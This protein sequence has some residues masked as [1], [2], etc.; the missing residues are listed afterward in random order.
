MSAPQ[1]FPNSTDPAVL[2]V[3]SYVLCVF[4]AEGQNPDMQGYAVRLSNF[5]VNVC[6][7]LLIR[8]SEESVSESVSALLLQVYTLMLCAFISLIRKQLSVADAHFA[9]T[10]TVSPLA[11]YLLYA[12]VR[13]VL[14]KRSYLFRRLGDHRTY[15]TL[16]L[17][18][19]P[20][21]TIMNLLIY[22]ANVFS[23]TCAPVTLASWLLFEIEAV[24]FSFIFASVF[25]GI[26]VLVWIF[27]SLRHFRDIRGEY[28]RHKMKAQ[29]WA[30]FSWIQW[31][32]LSFKSFVLAQW[33]VITKSHPWILTLSISTTY[34]IWGSSLILYVS[35]LGEFYH[36]IVAGIQADNG[37]PVTPYSPPDGYD[38]L[39]YGQLLAAGVAF[40]PLWQVLC[41]IWESR[42][43]MLAWIKR[44][45]SSLWNGIIFIFTG[46]R[47]PWEKVLAR[48]AEDGT[49][50]SI[51]DTLP[52]TGPNE[53]VK[54]I[55]RTSTFTSEV[56]DKFDNETLSNPAWRS[57]TS[58]DYSTAHPTSTTLY[59][60]YSP[61]KSY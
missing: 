48:R 39:G 22:F 13:K 30:R 16:S 6:L 31:F 37:Q 11:V 57:T 46:H 8:Y 15:L 53:E 58:L 45:P 35:D 5:I 41:L 44:Y 52:L 28:R 51:Y 9:L 42:G 14:K 59:D 27:Y 4:S 56:E 47:N 26:I 60:P 17:L 54:T 24:L 43:H 36:E 33:D 23:N 3:E 1:S 21:W 40:L 34:V 19:L 10:S 2:D 7:A 49:T 32:P 61:N 20:M 25:A 12:S 50:E 18:L 29:R 55:K 38:P